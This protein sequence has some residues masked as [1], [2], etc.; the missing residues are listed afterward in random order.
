[1]FTKRWILSKGAEA[2]QAAPEAAPVVTMDQVKG[3]FADEN[4]LVFGDPNSKVLFVEFSDP[5]CPYCHI[6]AGT[7]S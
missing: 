4:N 5:S 1:V 2:A 6:A 3:L 7:N